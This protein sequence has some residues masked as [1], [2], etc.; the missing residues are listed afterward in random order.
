MSNGED[1]RNFI[2]SYLTENPCTDATDQEFHEE[3]Y[4]RFGGKRQATFYGAQVVYKAQ[5]WLRRMSEEKLLERKRFGIVD[6]PADGFPK[7]VYVY[8]LWGY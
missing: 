6:A 2:L 8:S 4:Q 1:V 3:F 5:R 7:W